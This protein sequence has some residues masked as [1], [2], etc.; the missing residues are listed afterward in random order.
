LTILTVSMMIRQSAH[1]RPTS[2]EQ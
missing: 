1:P 2:C